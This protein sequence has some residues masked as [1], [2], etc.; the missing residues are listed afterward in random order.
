MEEEH[1][2]DV[3]SQLLCAHVSFFSSACNKNNNH[4]SK[5]N[6]RKNRIETTSFD[7]SANVLVLRVTKEN[8]ERDGELT[9]MFPEDYPKSEV[10]AIG[11]GNAIDETE[12]NE[13]LEDESGRY[14]N[15][16]LFEVLRL[17]GTTFFEGKE[18]KRIERTDP[19]P[20]RSPTWRL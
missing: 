12:L 3:K 19:A 1:E 17:V 15:K 14:A 5:K 16:T 13:K 2:G 7:A 8:E 4:V 11:D 20:N 6:K 10:M 9:L 18:L